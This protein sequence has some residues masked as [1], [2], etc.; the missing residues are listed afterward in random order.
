MQFYFKGFCAFCQ[1]AEIFLTKM[2]G[3]Y[4]GFIGVAQIFNE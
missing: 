2:I 3:F 1:E 4:L